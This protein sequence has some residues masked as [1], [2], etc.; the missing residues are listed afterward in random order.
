VVFCHCSQCRK[1]TGLYFAATK[2]ADEQLEVDG[3]ESI[4]WYQASDFAKRGFCRICGSALFWKVIG[5][6]ATSI[7]AGQLEQ[8]SGLEPAM[9]IFTADKGD[10]YDICDGLPQH[11]RSTGD[12]PVARNNRVCAKPRLARPSAEHL[13]LG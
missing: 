2:V 5:S 12:V 4:S 11:E 10:Y 6:N 3:Q 7:M 9:H 8:R 1:Q 13:A